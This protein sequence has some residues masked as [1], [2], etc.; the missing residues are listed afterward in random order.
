[1]RIREV[2]K[3][4]SR[5]TNS[6]G[7]TSCGIFIPWH[8]SF[9][10]TYNTSEESQREPRSPV[11]QWRGWST[12]P[13]HKHKLLLQSGWAMGTA[14]LKCLVSNRHQSKTCLQSLECFH[15][16]QWGLFPGN[17]QTYVIPSWF[18]PEGISVS[19]GSG[20]NSGVCWWSWVS[21]WLCST[22]VDK[23]RDS[24][25]ISINS[26][27]FVVITAA[28]WKFLTI[29]LIYFKYMELLWEEGKEL[30]VLIDLIL[31]FLLKTLHGSSKWLRGAELSSLEKLGP[32]NIFQTENLKLWVLRS[33]ITPKS[34]DCFTLMGVNNSILR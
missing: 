33:P 24:L 2:P 31:R 23:Q 21:D 30:P 26:A 3:G 32:F 6:C 7:V 15:L 13:P 29:K 16:Y 11:S 1:M 27:L 19:S 14:V 12:S 25:P 5:W 22:L 10:C 8:S 20:Q 17:F 28:N 4:E 18:S 34:S 9:V